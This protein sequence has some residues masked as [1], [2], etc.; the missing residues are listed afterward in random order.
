MSGV[1]IAGLILAVIPLLISTAEDWDT[2]R[3]LFGRF[4]RCGVEFEQFEWRLI[5]QK[6]IYHNEFSLLSLAL[7]GSDSTKAMLN[8]EWHSLYVS[9]ELDGE[10]TNQF[11]QALNGCQITTNLIQLRIKALE[12]IAKKYVKEVKQEGAVS[13]F[14]LCVAVAILT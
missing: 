8:G 10:F 9:R 11:S 7:T 2:V 3:R 13:I 4:K 14:K 5:A 12:D 6:T 1:E